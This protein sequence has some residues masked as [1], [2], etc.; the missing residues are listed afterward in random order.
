L[1]ELSELVN[2]NFSDNYIEKIENLSKNNKIQ[3]LL[4][5][6]N[7]IGMNGISDLEG[8]LEVPSISV[9][10]IQE[11]RIDDENILPEI[12]E[13]MPNLAVLYM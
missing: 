6:R 7:R 5:K 10:D 12:L 4:L 3:T 2:I 11:N 1:E 13:K 9:L 8:I